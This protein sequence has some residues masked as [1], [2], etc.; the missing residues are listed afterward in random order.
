MLRKLTDGLLAGIM[1]SIGGGVF[2]GCENKYVGAV[3]FC[4]A[5]VCICN[6]GYSLFTGKVGYIVE[7]HKKEDFSA[8]LL[9]LL[10]NAIAT[11]LIGMALSYAVPGFG[12]KALSMCNAKLG[13]DFF[14]TLIRAIFCG[15]LMY[16]AVCLFKEHKTPLG[17]FFCVP[18]FILSGY[19]HSI[20]N[21]FYFGASGI[22]S[23]EAFA[24]IW[25]VILGNSIGGMLFPILKLPRKL[26]K[27]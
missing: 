20:A 11:C 6:D 1:V 27:K 18:V 7:S 22:V 4:I 15:I 14:Q 8:L 26:G 10:G 16:L 9:G 12:E 23:L 13:Q 17:I 2:L 21:M 19:E 5:L 24:Y 3:M 25:V